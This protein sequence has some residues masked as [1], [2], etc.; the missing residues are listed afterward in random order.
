MATWEKKG[1]LKV[2]TQESDICCPLRGEFIYYFKPHL[3]A[4]YGTSVLVS[5]CI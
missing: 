2:S 5:K 1:I 4:S 3:T